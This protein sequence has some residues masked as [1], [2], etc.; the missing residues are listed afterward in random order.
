MVNDNVKEKLSDIYLLVEEIKKF[1]Q[2]YKT[3]L[4]EHCKDST[5][6]LILRRKTSNLCKCG[7]LL[8][9]SIP[10]TRYG[11]VILYVFPKKYNV[12]VEAGRIKNNVYCFFE[13]KKLSRYYV[14]LNE[15]WLLNKTEWE[16]K[17][18]KIVIFEGNVLKW[19]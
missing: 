12:L 11:E 15:Y 5:L 13:F 1:P 9:S 16:K 17:N 2:T 14:E 6:Q 8:K 18:K 3:I 4:K 19:I 7:T 10:G